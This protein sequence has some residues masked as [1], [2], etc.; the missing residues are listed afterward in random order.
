M[1]VVE[2]IIVIVVLFFIIMQFTAIPTLQSDF[3]RSKAQLQ[4]ND[5]IFSMDTLGVNWFDGVEVQDMFSSFL[6]NSTTQISLRINNVI[7]PKIQVGCVC[8]D[9]EMAYVTQALNNF[10]ING[11][12]TIFNVTNLSQTNPSFPI[13]LDVIILG[14]NFAE[15]SSNVLG[16]R[17]KILSYLRNDKGIVEA[18]TLPQSEFNT[19]QNEVFGIEHNA[20]DFADPGNFDN[21]FV[22]SQNL[23]IQQ[24]PYPNASP[25]DPFYNVFNNYYNIPLFNDDF[26]KGD[27]QWNDV[28]GTWSVSNE[29]Y[30]VDCSTTNECYSF[31]APTTLE[32]YTVEAEV[33]ISNSGFEGGMG[34]KQQSNTSIDDGVWFIMNTSDGGSYV[35]KR[36]SS[37]IWE[38]F[39]NP[40]SYSWQTNAWY[41]VR[42]HVPTYID[43]AQY[44]AEVFDEN[45]T[46]L[47]NHTSQD[48][49]KLGN[50]GGA[51]GLL[52]FNES[53]DSARY[54]NVRL[55]PLEPERFDDI[56]ANNINTTQTGFPNT[57]RTIVFQE[58]TGRAAALV[59][60]RMANGRG[61]TAWMVNSFSNNNNDYQA[62]LKDLVVWTAGY[63]INVIE[64]NIRQPTTLSFFKIDN[65]DTFEMYEIVMSIGKIF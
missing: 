29:E 9:S 49:S 52:R 28:S 14:P 38:D 23:N 65:Q 58:G 1:H 24:G 50:I 13:S 57:Y 43:T 3:P 62:L 6:S 56:I 36:K 37:G 53:G 15:S 10:T 39:D 21:D 34:F 8:T 61:R 55:K 2:I 19:V 48:D 25:A 7:K 20:T 41:K 59:N 30:E 60:Q 54:D 17:N 5:I 51:V 26:S 12:E 33:Y 63:G 16:V 42:I 46:F 31:S 11:R 40:G 44:T 22:F 18:A 45:G 32:N 64:N 35:F 4:A 27:Y 47:F